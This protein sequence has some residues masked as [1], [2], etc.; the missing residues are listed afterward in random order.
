MS[1]L[2][3]EERSSFRMR[4]GTA[5]LAA[6]RPLEESHTPSEVMPMVLSELLSLVAVIARTNVQLDAFDFIEACIVATRTV[7]KNARPAD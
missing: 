1:A 4:L 7:Y 2:T 3:D 5:L 6:A